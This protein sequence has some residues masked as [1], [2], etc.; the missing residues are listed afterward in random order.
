MT[1]DDVDNLRQIASIILGVVMTVG[2]PFAISFLKQSHWS[3]ARKNLLALATAVSVGA[4]TVVVRGNITGESFLEVSLAVFTAANVIYN[5][6]TK[7]T[8]VDQALEAKTP[9]FGATTPPTEEGDDNV[10]NGH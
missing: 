4:L 1:A 9:P 10:S 7:D 3:S 5:Q 2:L 8:Q 6:L